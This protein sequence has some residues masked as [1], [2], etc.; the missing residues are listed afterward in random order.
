MQCGDDRITPTYFPRT[1][2]RPVTER[3]DLRGLDA[4]LIGNV[5]HQRR[6]AE[7]AMTITKAATANLVAYLHRIGVSDA[8][9]PDLPASDFS[10]PDLPALARIVAGH[11][12]SIAYENLD[13]FTGRDVQLDAAALTAK[14]VH[15]GRGGGCFEHNLLLRSA[16]DALGYTTTGLAGRVLWNQPVDAPMP[17]RSHMLLRVDLPEGPH[18][19]DV[20]FG[21]ATLTG[22]LALKPNVEQTTPHGPFRLLPAGPAFVMEARLGDQWRPLYRFDLAEQYFA[23]YAMTNWYS[24]HYPNSRFVNTLLIGRPVTDRRYTL[25]GTK[26]GGANLAVHHLDGH[27]ERRNL[28]SPAAIRAALEEHFLIDLSGLPDLDA[29]LARLF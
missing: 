13:K 20:G 26:G 9:E 19:V 6:I 24:A 4:Q 15:G 10:V 22:V 14:L 21:V 2:T 16:L 29:F 18:I 12:R 3:K 27:T 23:D 25:S 1:S 28:N 17:P 11:A 8:P 5:P 7:G